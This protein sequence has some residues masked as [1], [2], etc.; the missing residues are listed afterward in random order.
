MKETHKPFKYLLFL[1]FIACATAISAQHSVELSRVYGGSLEDEGHAVDESEDGLIVVGGRSFSSDGDVNSN[2][3]GSDYWVMQ[4]TP[5]GDT[6]W[7]KSFGGSN[8]DDLRALTHSA[9]GQIATFGT[10]WSDD[11]DVTNNP[12]VIGAWLLTLDAAGN[13]LVSRVFAGAL[14]E[15]GVDIVAL[16]DGGYALLVQSTS[17]FL[18]GAENNGNFD[19]WVARTNAQGATLWAEFYGGSESDLAAQMIRVPGGFLIAGSSSSSDGNVSANQGGFDYWVVK[20]DVNGALLW[21]KSFGGS[22]D[23]LAADVLEL[24]DGNFAIVGTSDSQDGDKTVSYGGTDVWV[25]KIDPNGNLL[26]ERTYG[27]TEDDSGTK[28]SAIDNTQ[29]A[30]LAQTESSNVHLTGN[31][32]M[33]D[34]WIVF[35][36]AN[37]NIQ[38]QMNYGGMEDDFGRDI[39]LG[40]NG[41]L[42]FCGSTFSEDGN[43]PNTDLED[44]NLWLLSL[45]VDTVVCVENDACFVMDVGAGLIEVASNGPIFCNAGCN[46]GTQPGPAGGGCQGFSGLTTW[47]KIRTDSAAEVLTIAVTSAEF[48]QPQ[49][50][51]MQTLNCNMFTTIDCA[52]GTNGSVQLNNIDVEP[53]T[54]YY[55]VV[56]DGAGLSGAF[57]IC[58]SALDVNFC[59]RNPELY[60]ARTSMGSPLNGPYMPGEAVTFC[61]EVTM[62]D[63]LE[64]NGLQGIQPTFGGG[65]DSASFN[66][67]GMP[68]DVDTMLVPLSNGTW[69]WWPVGSVNYNF[70]NV[71]QGYPGGVALPAGWYFINNDDPPPNDDPDETIG[72]ISDCD[73]DSSR[74]KVCFTLTTLADCTSNAPLT[75]SV[76]S[77]ADGEIGSVVSTACQADPPLSFEAVL[78]CCTMPFINPIPNL[79]LCSGDT[80]VA[81]FESALDPPVTY[82]WEVT[83][84]G[85]V[86]GAESGS[87]SF[88]FQQ[89]FNF[90]TE[91]ALASYTVVG[92]N[93]LCETQVEEF[94]VVVRVQPTASMTLLSPDTICEGEEV[95]LRFDFSG[96]PPFIAEFTLNGVPQ[97]PFF[98][99]DPI[100]FASFV[101]DESALVALSS[102]NDALCPGNANGAFNVIVREIP[103]S[104]L[105]TSICAGDTLTIGDQQFGATGTYVAILE[106]GAA[107]GCDSLVNL[108]LTVNPTWDVTVQSTICVGDTFY[109]G[110]SAYTESGEYEQTIQSSDGCDSTVTLQLAVVTEIVDETNQVICPGNSVIFDGQELTESGTYTKV[111]PISETCDSVIILNLNVVDNIVLTQTVIEPDT[112]QN[113]G[114]ISISVGGGI[115][116]Y[117]YLWSTGDTTQDV[118]GLP[119]GEYSLT[120][121]DFIGCSMVFDFFL[122]TSTSQ[123][124]AGLVGME[125]FPNPAR[126][127]D[128]LTVTVDNNWV[129]AR[130]LRLA[131]VDL[132]GRVLVDHAVT[133]GPQKTSAALPVRSLAAGLYLVRLH[134]PADGGVHTVRVVL[135]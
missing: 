83:T 60:V 51:V 26:W 132:H 58:A 120:V 105:V 36:D 89:L 63:K 91:P 54:A 107:N 25:V 46:I 93:G 20:I 19:Y 87:G 7:S 33:A 67:L 133:L 101:P 39:A 53:D 30:M 106:G 9:N 119:T 97:Q 127:G 122:T 124:I 21:E 32:G 28:L 16:A 49:I 117:A 13:P 41:T 108:N 123:P 62:W 86:V 56:G 27:G 113:S 81:V 43:L 8:N 50:A 98:S 134:D 85:N 76:K 100:A 74:W 4:L 24:P 40:T 57:T 72:D 75:V 35:L 95:L 52:I 121:T 47:Y 82:E 45:E 66:G 102:F 71:I 79:T 92:T 6:L 5:E 80:L 118:S 34:A 129:S 17:P 42:Y 112:G 55:V 44:E 23:D 38:R 3:E 114:A 65:W 12:G 130:N 96:Q 31:K 48:N 131:L 73:P 111:V 115:P 68:V 29:F 90:G 116:P 15:Q 61:Y 104:S 59:N 64:C 77:F 135:E 110:G 126:S 128:A 11:G 2:Q 18:E 37:G 78:N 103:E 109:I 94:D 88:L 14:G 70:T 99:E 22:G 125:V 10:T 84:V 69:D 1:L